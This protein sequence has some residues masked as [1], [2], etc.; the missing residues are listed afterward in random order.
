MLKRKKQQRNVDEEDTKWVI[1]V[2]Y[3]QIRL[4]TVGFRYMI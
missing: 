4:S 1:Y 3:N 2:R